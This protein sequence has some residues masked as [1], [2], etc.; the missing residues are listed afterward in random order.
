[1][2]YQSLALKSGFTRLSPYA[3]IPVRHH[4][5]D[6]G[7]DIAVSTDAVIGPDGWLNLP[8]DL[9]T[10]APEGYYFRLVGRSSTI[11]SHGLHVVE[12]IIDSGFR[13]K[14]EILV[15]NISSENAELKVGDRIAQLIPCLV[16]DITWEERTMLTETTRGE[17][18]YGSTG[19]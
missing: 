15:H 7:Y 19:R 12:G 2:P 8:T 18:G 4:A 9:K 14:L 17:N 13:G 3:S 11:R 16:I 1:V 5:G 6:A 10:Q